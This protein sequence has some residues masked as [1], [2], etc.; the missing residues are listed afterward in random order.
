MKIMKENEMEFVDFRFT[1]GRGTLQHITYAVSFIDKDLLDDGFYF[2]GSSIEGWQEIHQSDMLLKPD[3]SHIA[4]DPFTAQPT[5][6][7][8]CDVHEPDSGDSYGRD[9]RSIAKKAEAYVKTCGIADNVYFGPEPEFFLFDSVKSRRACL[10]PA[11]NRF[12]W[13]PTNSDKD[14]GSD[15]NTGHRP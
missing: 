4:I 5:V 10:N 2:D 8:F 7:V 3:L 11:W 15:G 12:N 14:Y 6:I 13:N 1:D 9:P